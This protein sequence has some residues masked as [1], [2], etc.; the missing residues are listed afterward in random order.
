M[1]PAAAWGVARRRVREVLVHPYDA[2]LAAAPCGPCRSWLLTPDG[3]G[4]W[5]APLTDDAPPASTS[6]TGT[7]ERLLLFVWGRLALNDLKTEGDTRV[8]RAA[9]RLGARGVA[10]NGPSVRPR[11][12]PGPS[13]STASRC[14]GSGPGSRNA[15][16]RTPSCRTPS[17]RYR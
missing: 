8:F 14:T 9:D 3:T 2:Q 10:V 16:R 11:T 13:T 1:S 15:R 17:C 7:A 12:V 6:A 5:P 4:A